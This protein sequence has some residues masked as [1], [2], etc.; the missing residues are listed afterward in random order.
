MSDIEKL[1]SFEATEDLSK[2]WA[3]RYQE[4]LE[5]GLFILSDKTKILLSSNE[6]VD[7]PATPYGDLVLVKHLDKNNNL[8]EILLQST[9]ETVVRLL[10]VSLEVIPFSENAYQM[11]SKYRKIALG[12][13]DFNLYLDKK[14]YTSQ[15]QEVD[16]LG[17]FISHHSYRVSEGL[18]EEKGVGGLWSKITKHLRP[19]AFEYWIN[20]ETLET[21][22]GLELSETLDQELINQSNFTIIPRR[23]SHILLF[24]PDLEWQ[25]WSDRDDTAPVTNLENQKS[26]IL[27]STEASV[28]NLVKEIELPVFENDR[29]PDLQINNS[30]SPKFNLKDLVY[31]KEFKNIYPVV[32]ILVDN[33]KNNTRYRLAGEKVANRLWQEEGLELASKEQILEKLENANLNSDFE[34]YIGLVSIKNNQEFATVDNQLPT[35]KL[36]YKKDVNIYNLSNQFVQK[37]FNSKISVLSTFLVHQEEEK[38]YIYLVFELENKNLENINWQKL[39]K[40]SLNILDTKI[41]HNLQNYLGRLHNYCEIYLEKHL[42]EKL[43]D[44][45]SILPSEQDIQDRIEQEVENRLN[46]NLGKSKLLDNDLNAEFS[47]TEINNTNK[48]L[49]NLNLQIENLT[50]KLQDLQKYYQTALDEQTQNAKDLQEKLQIS[51]YLISELKKPKEDSQKN[52]EITTLQSEIAKLESELSISRQK[53]KDLENEKQ[54]LS[55]SLEKLEKQNLDLQTELNQK[56]ESSVNLKNEFDTLK[57]QNLDLYKQL[58]DKDLLEKE[59]TDKDDQN[60]QALENLKQQYQELQFKYD[61]SLKTAQNKQTLNRQKPNSQISMLKLMQQYSKK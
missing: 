55:S 47:E 46:H 60:L 38:L 39:E 31:V 16:F 3:E 1:A 18:A 33:Y 25:I 20:T 32:D 59:K 22:T 51:E 8:D 48:D 52:T 5:K 61:Q 40:F 10:D 29:L 50:T 21:K 30:Y 37:V 54:D 36:D 14:E 27:E 44:T 2:Y 19:K 11:V 6:I 17:H 4:V 58:A 28:K 7:S 26:N 24:P 49:D 23:N 9:I 45:L 34:I 43:E 13:S 53:I 57:E 15:I 12:I 41:I 35:I 56:K 42:N